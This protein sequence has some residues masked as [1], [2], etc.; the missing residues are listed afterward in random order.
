MVHGLCNKY[1]DY[2]E[3]PPELSLRN[4][5]IS[6]LC[7]VHHLLRHTLASYHL[8]SCAMEALPAGIR[9]GEHLRAQ[10]A[11]RDPLTK[12]AICSL[13]CRSAEREYQKQ[14]RHSTDQEPNETV[15]AIISII[16]D[17]LK[18]AA[19]CT[20]TLPVVGNVLPAVQELVDRVKVNDYVS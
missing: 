1:C 18:V 17:A 8:P 11:L 20:S 7:P 12:L 6:G 2:I 4:P 9:R 14:S 13:Y 5:L 16:Q 10:T 15:D 3:L 19:A